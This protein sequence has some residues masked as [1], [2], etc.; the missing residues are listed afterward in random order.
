MIKISKVTLNIGVG[1]SGEK[2]ESAKELLQRLTDQKPVETLSKKRI[3]TW[4]IRRGLPIGVKVTLRGKKALEF[5]DKCFG[6]IDK[7]IKESSFDKEGNLSFGVREYIDL[8]GVKYNPKIGMFGFDV[9]VTFSK[10]G[11]RVKKRK[12]K[13]SSIPKRHKVTKEE[14]IKFLKEKFDVE[15]LG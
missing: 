9:N 2:L 10:A 15:V 12:M 5:L 1:S 7:K 11:Y 3:P 4:N 13:K 14:A 6:S 8:P